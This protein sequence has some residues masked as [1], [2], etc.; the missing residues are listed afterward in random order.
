MA[1][2][3]F[4]YQ[5]KYPLIFASEYPICVIMII[6]FQLAGYSFFTI[7]HIIHNNEGRE[8]YEIR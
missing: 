3:R 4:E 6:L 2:V 8:Y 5:E 1:V 7:S